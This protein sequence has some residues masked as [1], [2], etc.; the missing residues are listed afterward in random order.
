MCSEIGYMAH[1]Q[2]R[3]DKFFVSHLDSI[4]HYEAG[5]LNKVFIMV[6]GVYILSRIVD[7]WHIVLHCGIS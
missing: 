5:N 7:H 2:S 6:K 1:I 3:K 4:P